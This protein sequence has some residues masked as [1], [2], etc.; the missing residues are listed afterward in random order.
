MVGKSKQRGN[1]SSKQAPSSIPEVLSQSP[2]RTTK[3]M[4]SRTH[5]GPSLPQSLL[6]ELNGESSE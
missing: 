4:S 5:T 2:S 6:E 1:N 3:F